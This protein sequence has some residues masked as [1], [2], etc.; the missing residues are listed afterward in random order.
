VSVYRPTYRDRKTGKLKESEVYWLDFTFAGKRIQESTRVKR[1]TVAIEVE[2]QKRRELER[3][4]A[5]LPSEKPKDRIRTVSEGLKTYRKAFPVNHRHKSV[6]VVENRSVHVERLLG[7]VLLPDLTQERI[8]EY[9]KRRLAEESSNRT[10]NLE[11]MTLSRAIGYTWKALWPKVKKLEENHDVGR[12]LEAEEETRIFEAAAKNQS[13]LIYPYLMTLAWTG[14]RADEARM[15]RWNQVDFEADQIIVGKSKTEAGRGRIIPMSVALKTAL[16]HHL[17]WYVSK[18]GPIQPDW[19]VFPFS[20]RI[21]PIDPTK[22]ATSLKRAWQS[23]REKAKVNCRLHDLRHSFCTKLAEA[24]VPESTM[25]DIM[26]HM[27]QAM[28]RRYSH[29]RAQARRDAI[30][31]VEARISESHVKVSPKVTISEASKS[32]VTH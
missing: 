3:S 10:I 5:G 21:K 26:G 30:T 20:N 31:A 27:S 17:S 28:L 1:K 12:A 23:V 8:T 32:L 18:F 2:K 25:L 22:P 6:L 13:H 11:L 9:M 4:L 24:G 29:I 15:L 14:I 16:Q 7:S 19:F